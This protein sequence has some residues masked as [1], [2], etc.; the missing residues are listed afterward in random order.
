MNTDVKYKSLLHEIV[1]TRLQ[2]LKDE[3]V[4]LLEEGQNTSDIER[5][6]TELRF[7]IKQEKEQAGKDKAYT[8]EE[9]RQE[10]KQAYQSWEGHDAELELLF[11]DGKSVAELAA[12]FGRNEGAIRSRIKKLELR[13]KYG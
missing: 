9:K 4:A 5:A 8:V 6:I 1:Y 10:H 11:C 2:E 13:E 12:H 7:I 3:R